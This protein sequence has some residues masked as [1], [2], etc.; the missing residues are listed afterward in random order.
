[1]RVE[2]L[3]KGAA[4][5]QSDVSKAE[6]ADQRSE[7]TRSFVRRVRAATRRKYTPEEKIRIV[8][9]GFR[10]EVTVNDLCRREGIKPHSYYSWT[11]EFMEAG[12]ERLSRDTVRDAT[13]QEIQDLKRGER[14]AQAAGS[15]AIPRGLPSEKNGHTNAPERR[16]YQRMS[17][18]EKATVLASVAASPLAKR[19]VLRDLGVP[20]ST[21]YR[22]LMRQQHQ[23]G[24]EDRPGASA[25]PWN[26]LRPQ[27]ERSILEAARE[28]PELSS[29]QLAAWSTDNLAF[30]VSESTVYRILCREGLVKSPE[31]QLKAGK[32]YHRK[33]SGPHQMWAT[34][35][36]YFKVIGWGY[37][38]LVTVMDDYS[39]FILAHKLQRDMTTDSLIEVVQEAVDKTGMTEVPVADRTSLLSDNGSGYVSR[40]FRDYLHLVGIKHILAAPFHPQTNGK[41]ERYHQSIKRDVKQVPYEMPSALEAAI[42]AFVAYYNYRRY[43]KALA[44][45]TPADMLN[46]R[47]EQILQRRKE[48]QV[49]TLERRRRYNKTLREL[50]RSSSQ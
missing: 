43:H 38:Y 31:M 17:A 39:R 36:S 4:M 48:V 12:R 34:D 27:E 5:S 28:M 2:Y 50:P 30:A 3:M 20:K 23:Q 14:R 46:G 33:T 1:M 42:A 13:R 18:V 40:G 21:Y 10:R 37:Y 7:Q 19:R 49:Q 44:N 11:K 41:L 26:R 9:E 24:L 16:R 35:A 47:R 29:R 15:R 32:E 22:W 25:P 45:V 6:A 8:L